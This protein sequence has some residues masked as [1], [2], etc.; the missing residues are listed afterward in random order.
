MLPRAKI[1]HCIRD[2]R[3]AGLSF[4]Q[5][6]FGEKQKH[7]YDLKA[8]GEYYRLYMNLMEHW[9]TLLPG[10]IF[11]INYE[12]IVDNPEQ[13]IRELLDHCGLDF[14]PA[15][16]A[17]HETDRAVRTAS[18]LQVRRPLYTSSVGRWKNYEKQLQPLIEVLEL[19]GA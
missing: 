13:N 2:P 14:H 18:F 11:E 6:D 3:D 10:K 7:S 12:D 5:I 9:K 4:Y 19:K 1:V 16:L 8:I 15:C 17:F